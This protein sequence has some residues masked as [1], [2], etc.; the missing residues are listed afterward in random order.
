VV[1]VVA[2]GSDWLGH[3]EN[4][5]A[6][7]YTRDWTMAPFWDGSFGF[8]ANVV[9]VLS[10]PSCSLA[11]IILLFSLW[12]T[13]IRRAQLMLGCVAVLL[14]VWRSS[15]V[16]TSLFSNENED[17]GLFG[18][19]SS[20]LL[21]LQQNNHNRILGDSPAQTESRPH[22]PTA[23][24]RIAY[25]TYSFLATTEQFEK[26]I[27]ASLD[28]WLDEGTYFVVLNER[29]RNAYEALCQN[30]NHAQHYCARIEPIYV[31]CPEH[32]WGQSPCCKQ[33][34]GLLYMIQHHLHD[35]DWFLYQDDDMYLRRKYLE[36]FLQPLNT[37]TP[38]I[39]T[40]GGVRKH[41][42][43]R[44]LGQQ[45]FAQ[46]YQRQYNCSVGNPDF[47]YP[48]GQPVVYNRA[49]LSRI[50]SG[51][52]QGGLVRQCLTYNVTHDVGNAVFH[53]MYQLPEVRFRIPFFPKM[54]KWH[55]MGIH[56]VAKSEEALSMQQV[57]EKF[58]RL[59]QYDKHEH[60]WFE[61]HGFQQ[62]VTFRKHGD[63]ETWKEW[64]TMPTSDCAGP[65]DEVPA[66]YALQ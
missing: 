63:P 14:T 43:G 47:T 8:I 54:F 5:R 25:I 51:L 35:F 21:S 65:S 44:E 62:T 50:H 36:S 49:A 57:H 32:K 34:Q 60:H 22:V 58:Q 30:A 53:W 16:V 29:W 13:M 59:P 28:T 6:S 3:K 20:S 39:A 15:V 7:R 19:Q 23:S 56:G 40:S 4:R 26:M 11:L 24:P 45:S 1:V 64:H 66:G 9:R 42:K 2:G 17:Y 41:S 48:W 12:I 55:F 46:A 18:G 61:A 33:Q 38:A 31:D 10:L 52:T 27:F 37:T